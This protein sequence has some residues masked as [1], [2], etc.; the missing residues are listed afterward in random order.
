MQ[1]YLYSN[2]MHHTIIFI[3]NIPVR[4]LPEKRRSIRL[5]W[6][7]RER[8]IQCLHPGRLSADLLRDFLDKRKSRIERLFTQAFEPEEGAVLLYRGEEYRLLFSHVGEGEDI[9]KDDSS[10]TIRA[11]FYS[12]KT[13]FFTGWKAF[14]KQE[15]PLCFEKGIRFYEEMTGCR[16]IRWRFRDMRSRWGSASPK[17]AVTL[18]TLLVMAPVAVADYVILHEL[19]HIK[20]PDHS[21]R[22]WQEVEKFMP[23]Y[24]FRRSWLRDNGNRLLSLY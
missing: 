4:L 10:K 18:N 20:V 22:F 3:E 21:P 16:D 24:R 6:D 1:L 11:P 19:S 12:E 5:F 23:D 15:A 2:G 9:I 14:L 13:L 8:M 17:G 7:R